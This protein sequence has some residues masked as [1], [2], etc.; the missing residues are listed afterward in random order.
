M[1]G[2]GLGLIRVSLSLSQT[3]MEGGGDIDESIGRSTDPGDAEHHTEYGLHEEDQ[4]CTRYGY[5]I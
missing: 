5:S 2:T 1:L 4:L 3:L